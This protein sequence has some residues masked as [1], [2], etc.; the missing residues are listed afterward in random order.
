[1][2]IIS[3]IESFIQ[4][5]ST[6]SRYAPNII[7]DQVTEAK[8]ATWDDIPPGIRPELKTLL[9][10]LGIS[11]LFSHQTEAMTAILKRQNIVL[12]SG[13]A[14]G[15]S[16]CYQIP[17]LNELLNLPA[18]RTFLLFPTKALAQDQFGKMNQMLSLF[19]QGLPAAAKFSAG[20]YDGDTGTD[21]RSNIRKNSSLIF[22]NPDMLHLGILPNHSLWSSFFANL[23]YVVLDEVH[24]Y[25]GV[26]GSNVANIIR[27]LRRICR[28]YGSD[29]QF[30]C[31]SATLA[32]SIELSENLTET[33]M[34][35]LTEDGS[36]HG[37]RVFYILNPPMIDPQ[38]GIRRSAVIESTSLAKR[39]LKT[40]CQ[41]ILFSETRRNVEI[42]FRYLMDK[43]WDKERIRSY[44]SGYLAEDRR[45]I[46][47]DLRDRKID[48]VVSTNALELGIDIGGLDAVFINGY[49]GTICGT[50]QQSGRAG[51]KG[52]TA[53]TVLVA[54]ANPL[55]QYICS[56]PEYLFENSP[57]R[58]LIDPDNPEILLRQVL[59]AV[60][61]MAM[62]DTESFGSLSCAQILPILQMLIDEGKIRKVGTRYI[63]ILGKYPSADVSIRNLSSQYRLM[64]GAEMIGYVD[65]VSANWMTHPNAI[66]LHQGDTWI[67]NNLD[68]DQKRVD[69]Q[70]TD[71][72][73]YTQA[74]KTTEIDLNEL[75]HSEAIPGGKKYIGKVT[76][77][78]LITGFKKLRFFTQEL[79]GMEEL[80]MA[81]SILPTVAWW[82]A[83]SP[84]TVQTVR[85]VA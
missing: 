17:I 21:S 11:R 34:L 28:F 79:L 9:G 1:M 74:A 56:H 23:R 81:P 20:I 24:I 83:L 69:L 62:L 19:K 70:P 15:K 30:I 80:E 13:V 35:S 67:V 26:F 85:S 54:T 33:A 84:A 45:Q 25:R 61:D 44:R 64:N 41:A 22:T 66:Y 2:N 49:P 10:K 52:S 6:D 72:N 8:A 48:I 4:S 32:N 43:A 71:A 31:T 77:T 14:S 60:Y 40:G 76:V 29:P 47:S 57:E 65:A 59:C 3:P 82:I 12:S 27:R 50:R 63:G 39:F 68:H 18:S 73:Y 53:L 5:V 38:L 51:R 75:T 78:S 16:L 7:A 58:A 37:K 55:D 46:E 42:L 36:P